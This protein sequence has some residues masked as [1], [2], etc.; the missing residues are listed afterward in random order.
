MQKPPFSIKAFDQMT[1]DQFAAAMELAF[2]QEHVDPLPPGHISVESKERGGHYAKW[3]R[4]GGNGK[5]LSPVY[6]GVAGSEAH[7]QALAQFEDL[8]RIERAAK[9]LR[10]LGLAAEDNDAAMVLAALANAGY[11]RAGGVLVGTRAFRCL[12]NHLGYVMKPIAATQDVDIAQPTN[13]KLAV[14]LPG[15]GLRGLLQSTGLKFVD[16]PALDRTVPSSSWRV[17]GREVKLD[18]LT[19]ANRQHQPY[20]TVA[21]PGL[22]AHATALAYLDYLQVETLDAIAIGKSQL[23]P[24]RVSSPARF[25]WHKLAVSQLRAATFSAKSDKDLLQAACLFTV[26][27]EDDLAALLEA[28]SAMSA[29]MLK[30]VKKAWPAFIRLFGAWR[31]DWV[32][33]VSV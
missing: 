12:S 9:H 28:K 32:D 33:A 29:A 22:A 25:G 27:G 18:L 4:Q 2:A 6:L 19:A 24:V 1:K 11:F 8:Q 23:V 13:I 20:Q 31:P 30:H 15:A 7:E 16:V 26:L 10:K 14:P 5:P 21:I 17:I 3:R